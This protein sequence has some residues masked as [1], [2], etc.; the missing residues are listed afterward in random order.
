MVSPEVVSNLFAECVGSV[1]S[2]FR[3]PP[4]AFGGIWRQSPTARF[5]SGK[6]E[7][8]RFTP[9]PARAEPKMVSPE[10][11]LNLFAECVGSVFSCLSRPQAA[12]WR[13]LHPISTAVFVWWVKGKKAFHGTTRKDRAQ[14]GFTRGG[15][16]P[17]CRVCGECVFML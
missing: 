10:V 4:R 12:S 13:Y 9:P 7:K 6:R 16:K 15:F 17:L 11:A 5:C 14:N 1:F 3:R 2:C 8:R